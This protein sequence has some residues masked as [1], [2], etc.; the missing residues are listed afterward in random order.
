MAGL[1]QLLQ[2]TWIFLRV[3]TLVFGGG[4]VMVPLLEPDV[5]VQHHWLTHQEFVDAVALGQMTPGPVLVTATF[6]GYKVAGVPGAAIATTAIF[7]PSVL[8]LLVLAR[9]LARIRENRYIR[10]FLKGVNVAIVGLIVAAAVNIARVSFMAAENRFGLPLSA[11]GG[12][13]NLDPYPAAIAVVGSVA[14]IRYKVDAIYVILAAAAV[15][16]LVYR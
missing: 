4:L 6:I 3:G 16:L 15:G 8:M 12:T 9:Q 13:Y 5:V 2:M 10:G 11:F 1:V 14:M 7:L